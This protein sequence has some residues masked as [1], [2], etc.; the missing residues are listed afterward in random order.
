MELTISVAKNGK[1][2]WNT[3]KNTHKYLCIIVIST[4]LHESTK[5][6]TNKKKMYSELYSNFNCLPEHFMNVT[7][8]NLTFESS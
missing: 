6:I 2:A 5:C 7:V 8:Q 4:F 3:K 1:N